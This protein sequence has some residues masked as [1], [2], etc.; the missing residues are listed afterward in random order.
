MKQTVDLKWARLCV[1]S[2]FYQLLQRGL[3]APDAELAEALSIGTFT[4]DCI[5]IL[6]DLGVSDRKI[7]ALK[8]HLD[9]FQEKD[10]EAL[11][12]GMK[13]DYSALFFNPKSAPLTLYETA[14]YDQ[15]ESLGTPLFVSQTASIVENSYQNAGMRIR[16]RSQEPPDYLLTE[17]EFMMYL[18][19]KQAKAVYEEQDQETADIG[20]LIDAFERDHI[21][22]WVEETLSEMMNLS[23]QSPYYSIAY[24]G[25]T[26]L[27]AM[28]R[29]R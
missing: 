26:G 11:L 12:R 25:C 1:I 28:R 3:S 20:S 27:R 10:P 8:A 16:D 15:E 14:F 6:E 17:L 9:V 13:L 29:A 23:R 4:N 19:A 2:D 21:Y 24:A 18:Y 7:T 22:R 5:A